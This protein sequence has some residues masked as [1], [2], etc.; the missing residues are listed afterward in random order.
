MQ[1]FFLEGQE[2]SL[3]PKLCFVIMPFASD[4]ANAYAAIKSIVEDYCGLT[5]VRA[6]EISK[7]ER[8]TDDIWKTINEARFLIA[9][10]TNQNP[11]VFYEVG[12]AHA[13]KK[14]VILL[15]QDQ[16]V[17]FDLRGI[18]YLP[19]D[20]NNLIELQKKLPEFIKNCIVT[21]P[22]I[23]NRNYHPETRNISYVKIT[24]LQSPPFVYLGQPFE[25][26]IT[27]KNNGSDA[28]QGYFSVS[29]PDG[30]DDLSIESNT[31]TKI[32]KKGELWK[33]EQVVLNYPI[34]EGYKFG[35]ASTWQSGKEYYIKVR[36]YARHK[37]FF[38]FYIN[39]CCGNEAG[40]QWGFDP[41]KP[42]FDIDQRDENVY[43]G[44]IEIK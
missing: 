15:T 21:I 1:N 8:I 26:T 39:A 17:P 2:F 19:Y 28:F 30:V 44:I 14:P 36:G 41:N 27:A 5:C 37:G 16:N 33:G 32:G 18:R 25:I 42:L 10:L 20:A 11:N 4:L 35:E 3:H 40:N 29:F 12:L 7:A 23:W 43:C 6:D 38:R 22:E 9:D 31:E 34:A 24:S 13:I